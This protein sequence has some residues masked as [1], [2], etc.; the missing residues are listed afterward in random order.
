MV[1]EDIYD[2]N[3]EPY[4]VTRARDWFLKRTSKFELTD[5]DKKYLTGMTVDGWLLRTS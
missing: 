4:G 3:I 2:G 1:L 5:I